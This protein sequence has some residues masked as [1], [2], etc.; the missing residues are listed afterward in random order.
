MAYIANIKS[1][2]PKRGIHLCVK[3]SKSFCMRTAQELERT[4]GLKA[5]TVM[6]L[7]RDKGIWGLFV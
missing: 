3:G 2:L 1:A 6:P 7:D 5:W 4:K